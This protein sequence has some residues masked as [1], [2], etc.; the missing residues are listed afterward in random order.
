[1]LP[2]CCNALGS[3]FPVPY[4]MQGSF[5]YPG[6]WDQRGSCTEA[7]ESLEAR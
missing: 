1:M 4:S 6:F 3:L 5:D 7:L 2:V